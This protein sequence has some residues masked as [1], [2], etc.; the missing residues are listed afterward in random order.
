[1]RHSKQIQKAAEA[2]PDLIDSMKRPLNPRA[3]SL[4][5]GDPDFPTPEHICDAAREA[6]RQGY[7][8]YAPGAGDKDLIQAICENLSNRYGCSYDP[9]G[10]VITAGGAGAIYLICATYLSQGDEVIVFDP[11]YT[12][13]PYC[14]MLAGA[15]PV[16][17]PFAKDFRVDRDALKKAINSKTKIIFLVNPNN[18]TGTSL[19]KEDVE[20]VAQMAVEHDV[21]L[22]SDEV[23]R[24]I[25]YDG[26]TH[27]SAGSIREAK[28]HTI[29]I[30]SFSKTYAMTGWSIGYIATT[31]E[32]AQSL[33]IV[34]MARP[35]KV[36]TP[37]Q[38]A[39]LAALKGP[40][41]CV[42][43]M[44]DQ[45]AD[46]RLAIH[47]KLSH[48][49]KLSYVIPDSAFYF[50][51]HF[52][53]DMTSSQMVD[54]LYEKGVLVRSGTQFGNRGQGWFRLTYCMALKDAV[55]GIDRLAKAINDLK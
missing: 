20:F 44:V 8:H 22:V 38:R 36:N 33:K 52:E 10:I 9:P 18:P 34:R 5:V 30:D 39:A 50:F 24:E 21:I 55:E 53:A 17:V 11:S 27:F 23:Y 15:V 46:R 35:G 16:A 25:Y 54:Y 1:M 12:N 3:I 31:P 4:D 13:Q 26:K 43:Q 6:M 7:T 49:Q 28:A 47:S 2:Y 29:L 32:L 19:P 41:D 14:A 45:Y 48:I 40:Q 37:A 51:C 42:R